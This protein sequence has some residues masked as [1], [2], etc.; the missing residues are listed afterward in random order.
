MKTKLA[1]AALSIQSRHYNWIGKLSQLLPA[2]RDNSFFSRRDRARNTLDCIADAVLTADTRGMVTYLNPVAEMMTGWSHREALAQPLEKVFQ[3]VD[4]RSRE[5]LTSPLQRLLQLSRPTP[6]GCM[7]NSA[8][9]YTLIRRDGFE[10]VIEDSVAP[11]H[12]P[13]GTTV[14]AVIV[15]HDITASRAA[16]LR[17]AHM[18]QHDYLTGLPNRLLLCERLALAIVLA[19]RHKKLV[20][21]L[22]L[23][24]DN[25]K[26]VNDSLGHTI[27]DDLLKS[28]SKRLTS[29]VRDSD[30]VC[31]QG[32]DEF[33]ILLAEIETP[34]DAARISENIIQ[35]FLAPHYIGDEELRVTLSIGISVC[36]D[37]GDSEDTA[38]RSAN[39]A[40][41]NADT[42]M[43][44]AKLTGR[45]NYQF[46]QP[47][48]NVRATHRLMQQNA[49]RRALKDDE[50][51]L[52]YQPQINLSSGAII[53]AEALIRWQDPHAGLIYPEQFIRTAEDCG[54]I[55]PL[56]KWVLREVCRQIRVWL[57]AGLPVV[58]VSI[59]IS[60]EELGHREFTFGVHACLREFNLNT[61]HLELELT[62][63][64]LMRDVTA[65]A[66]VLSAL[67]AAGVHIA[68]DDFGK[69]YSSLSYLKRLPIN[70]LKIDQSFIQDID[71]EEDDRSIVGAIISMGQNLHQRVIAE[72]VTTE[73]QLKTLQGLGC[74]VGQG[75]LFS[76]PLVADGFATLLARHL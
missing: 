10:C 59:N 13:H 3:V 14:G 26:C 9:E 35:A 37:A 38:Q 24:L 63:S 16:A 62:E 76:E 52:H 11:L 4:S 2:A 64:V 44:H 1:D 7:E 53:G 20:G 34:L 21:L 28:V 33:V 22:F 48:M 6:R 42:A 31:R 15:F 45:N 8:L 60:A 29:C 68:L 17:M 18:A 58:P 51:V 67:R 74:E 41:E 56:G 25:F 57:D 66:L 39:S 19:R 32:G 23:D 69:G 72:G 54:L 12:D 65:S 43:Y 40:L 70:T 47:A 55:V 75:S 46:F 30:T 27:G 49:L 71:N 5:P 50:F 61:S 36:P 73:K